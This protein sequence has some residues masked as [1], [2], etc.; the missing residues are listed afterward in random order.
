MC[1]KLERVEF[2]KGNAQYLF[3][4]ARATHN[5]NQLFNS[6]KSWNW[7]RSWII[8]RDIIQVKR[9]HSRDRYLR[10]RVQ[11]ARQVN[12]V[13]C[14]I[15]NSNLKQSKQSKQEAL[16][17]VQI[18][19]SQGPIFQTLTKLIQNQQRLFEPFTYKS[20]KKF[21][22]GLVLTFSSRPWA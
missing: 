6:R 20:R 19:R 18:K 17:G 3:Q 12:Q 16:M 11:L 1:D 5:F 4:E 15:C 2:N 22:K 10:L 8:T 13:T 14:I 7:T 21:F 9:G